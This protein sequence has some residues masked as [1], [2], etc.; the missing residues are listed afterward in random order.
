MDENDIEEFYVDVETR[1]YTEKKDWIMIL[2]VND[3]HI[4]IKSDTGAQ[5]NVISET[6]IKKISPRPKLH[7]TKVR[8]RR[9]SGVVIPVKGKCMV[10]VTHKDREHTLAFIVVPK[11][12]QAILGL[13]ACER[14]NLLM[15]V[16]IVKG[17]G[18][19]EV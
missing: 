5:A 3:V 12:V 4:A 9:Y 19:T 16:L 14:L 1:N 11:K 15:R 13:S 2:K 8:V 7:A 10:K 17:E 6:E 18:D